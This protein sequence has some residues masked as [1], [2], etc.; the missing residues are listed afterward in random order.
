MQKDASSWPE[1]HFSQLL[2]MFNSLQN[3]CWKQNSLPWLPFLLSMCMFEV[4]FEP[5]KALAS[6][7]PQQLTG[8]LWCK[9][10]LRDVLCVVLHAP[11]FGGFQSSNDHLHTLKICTYV[12]CPGKTHT[13]VSLPKCC[14]VSDTNGKYWLPAEFS[15]EIHLF[16]YFLMIVWQLGVG[17]QGEVWLEPLF[18]WKAI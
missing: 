1:F 9:C 11:I 18:S 14:L 6:M 7:Y 5:L 16:G 2:K 17:R 12:V 4:L 8:V 15:V 10:A 13:V 3:L